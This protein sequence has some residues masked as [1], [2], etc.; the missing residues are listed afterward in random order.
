[1]YDNISFLRVV[2]DWNEQPSDI[3]ETRKLGKFKW[4]QYKR[5]T[6]KRRMLQRSDSTNIGLTNV[7]LVQMLDWYKRRTGTNVGLGQTSDLYK[8]RTSTNVGR[9]HL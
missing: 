9:V 3:K 2:S 7:G 6:H 5:R 8:R 4:Y 1:M